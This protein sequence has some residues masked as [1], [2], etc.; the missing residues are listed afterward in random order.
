MSQKLPTAADLAKQF[1]KHCEGVLS[2]L[3][4][5]LQ[6][7]A[8]DAAQEVQKK[9]KTQTAHDVKPEYKK[10]VDSTD[11]YIAGIKATKEDK[12]QYRVG[13]SEDH[14][15]V[16]RVFEYGDTRGIPARPHYRPV[17]RTIGAKVQGLV[18]KLGGAK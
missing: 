9:L 18:K 2:E 6:K 17:L 15:E 1:S 7:I 14:A 11:E 12:G 13:T 5:G 10:T 4:K 3:D 16:A 8:D